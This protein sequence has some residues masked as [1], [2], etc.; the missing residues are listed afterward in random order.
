MPPAFIRTLC[1]PL[2][3]LLAASVPAGAAG[4]HHDGE[5]LPPFPLP[6]QDFMAHEQ[7]IA[8]DRY[9]PSVESLTGDAAPAEL[10][11]DLVHGDHE[12][13]AHPA[14]QQKLGLW[15]TLVARVQYAPIH[16]VVSLIFLGAILHTFF[17]GKF[18]AMAHKIEHEH[19]YQV[20][21]HGKKY[22]ED[23]DPVSFKAT[24][25][26][27]LGE[28]E[29]IFG[30]WIVPLFLVVTF[31]P[32]YGWDTIV[33]YIDIQDYT[34]PVFVVVIMAIA[35]SRPIL[36]IAQSALSVVA[37]LGRH[38]TAAWW[39]SILTIAPVLGSFITEPAAMTIAA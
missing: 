6:L 36:Q 1:V 24:L 26:H 14:P 22:V 30:I 29:V 38:S 33:Y 19:G 9:G 21:G 39:L 28:V 7:E 37:A 2:L 10:P 4:G 13:A 8:L 27:F 32:G 35:S 5:D 3:C 23:K 20:R 12:T 17:A 25:F 16:L 15:E 31:W 11:P 34:E 18:M